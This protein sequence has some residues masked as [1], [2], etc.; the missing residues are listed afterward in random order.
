MLKKEMEEQMKTMNKGG[1][2]P[3]MSE[4]MS[5]FFGGE[6]PKRA[7]KKGVKQNWNTIPIIKF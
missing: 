5:S 4:L 7:P 1:S 6:Q 3:D 2:V